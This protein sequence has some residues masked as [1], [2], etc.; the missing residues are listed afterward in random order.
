MKIYI[1]P[2]KDPYSEALPTQAKRKRTVFRS[3][4]NGEQT[5][6]G[7]FFRSRESPFQGSGVQRVLDALPI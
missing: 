6:F 7:R 3:W 4:W 2:L 1:A 5:P